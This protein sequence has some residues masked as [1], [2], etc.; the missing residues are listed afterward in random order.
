MCYVGVSVGVSV[1]V[2]VQCGCEYEGE[3]EWKYKYKYDRHP[4][5]SNVHLH[6]KVSIKRDALIF[7]GIIRKD[8]NQ[9]ITEGS[10][11]YSPAPSSGNAMVRMDVCSSRLRNSGIELCKLGIV[12][13]W[14]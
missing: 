12:L 9:R 10:N 6:Y 5:S 3:C 1:G 2:G 4:Y 8:H 11:P 13:P 7:R 14:K